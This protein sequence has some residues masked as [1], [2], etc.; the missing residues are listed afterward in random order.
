AHE[1]APAPDPKPMAPHERVRRWQ[2]RLLDLSLLNRLINFRETTR[3]LKLE[4]PDLPALENAFNQEKRFTISSKTDGDENFRKEQ[5]ERQT[6]YSNL[7]PAATQAALLDLYRTRRST[8]E[9][10]G[11]N[12]LYLALGMLHWYE[13]DVSELPRRAPILL[14]P[15][16]LTRATA[17][18][19]YRYDLLLSDEPIRPNVTLLEKLR[20]EFG[21]DDPALATLPEDDRGI[22]VA[23]VF[24]NFRTAIKGI[25]RW[26]V[27]ESAHLGLF[28]FNKFLMWR[29]LQEHLDTLKKNRLVAHL[30]Q[31][32]GNVFDPR[33][34]PAADTL[35]EDLAPGDLLCTRDAD[36]SQ[37][38]AIRA[39]SQG[40]TF[41]LEGP[42]GT[43]KSQT[44][45]NM[46]ADSI[47]RGKR[48]LFVAEKMA[49]L[50]VVRDR[51]E[52]DGLGAFCLELHSAK[53]SKKEVLAQLETA[54][55]EPPAPEP[56]DWPTLCADLAR[57][58]TL[59]NAYVRALHAHHPSGETLYQVA[60][61]LATLPTGP[62]ITPDTDSIAAV[63]AQTLAAWRAALEELH[64]AAAMLD[65]V[66]AH[67]LRG[68]A[69]SQWS[70]S[71]PDQACAA[72]DAA[73]QSLTALRASLDHFFHSF[74]AAASESLI[75]PRTL[76][77]LQSLAKLLS[78]SP[79]AHPDL[80]LGTDAPAL[81][82]SL[83]RLIELGR[84]RDARCASLLATYRPE[85]LD[86]DI[87]PH[88]DRT[89]RAAAA[90]GLFGLWPRFS[91][92]RSMR[93]YCTGDVPPIQTLHRDLES[94]LELKRE[95]AQLAANADAPRLFSAR[96]NNAHPAWDE[97]SAILAW[98]SSVAD[99]ARPL[100]EAPHGLQLLSSLLSLLHAGPAPADL[101]SA[102][103]AFLN[104]ISRWSSAQGELDALLKIT[105]P[106]PTAADPTVPWLPALARQLER[107]RGGLPDLNTW[108]TWRDARDRAHAAGLA[109]IINLYEAGTLPL[110]ELK[111]A[112]E[113]GYAAAWYNAV[114][115]AHPAIREFNARTHQGHIERF[116]SLDTQVLA[117][118]HRIVRAALAKDRP[119]ASADANP[120][121]ELGILKRELSRK[122]RHMPTRRLIASI[123]N[124]LARL[125]P[126]FL[127]SPL[128]VAQ[129]LDAR[130]PPFDLVIFDEASQI[131]VW[132]SI[133]AI[134]RGAEVIV[135]G[136][137]RQL[138][139]TSFFTIAAEDE[140]QETTESTL[141]DME[142]ILQECNASSI[143]SMWLSWHYR[144]RHES[145]IAF[146]NFHY[147]RNQLHT[148]PSPIDRS[149]QLGVTLRHI[150][151]ALYDRGNSR[152]N[153]KEAELIV[154]EI[155]DLLS[156][157]LPPGREHHDSIG[158]VTFNQTQQTLI[159][160]LLDAKRR[161]LPHLDRFFTDQ[162]P[163]P[164]FVKNLE[165]VQGDERDIIIF[166]VTYGPYEVGKPPSMHFGPLNGSGG[167]RRLNVA[168]TRARKKLRVFSSIR[169]DDIDLRRTSALGVAH[170]KTFLDYADRGP[171]AI[172]E[173]T[174]L[175]TTPTTSTSTLDAG[176]EHAVQ[177][178]LT[179]RG[180]QVD[181]HVGCAG[182]RVDLAIRDP[183]RPGRYLLGIECDGA[184]YH[185]GKTARDRDRLR[186]A[187]LRS[188]GWNITR[189]WSTDWRINPARCIE[190]LEH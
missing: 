31:G 171:R 152:T 141:D 108:C 119:D 97:L 124:L 90:S 62:A 52:K 145:L 29:D 181:A 102:A 41:V 164:V 125:K 188:L 127:M 112:F 128:S 167:E 57:E 180:W 187:V 166:S 17:T 50:G 140:E 80:I 133:G 66:A 150:P 42:P 15:V 2:S 163:E 23:R 139:P 77:S 151:G 126:C 88:L 99:A 158:V 86:A 103:A 178:A 98:S 87:L 156:Q 134:A 162:V 85:L 33:P 120:Q 26:E 160:D 104:A 183:A 155:V 6:L 168:V 137:S 19:G 144:S 56:H 190:S 83:T 60:G 179:A 12:P 129:Y 82:A 53:A 4:I 59:L 116:A 51:L 101:L 169:A 174:S 25:N 70:F 115:D 54:L 94:I 175:P 106:A 84:Q 3:T 45:A 111:P 185:S 105:L 46:I 107:W 48:V 143:P 11:A 154:E 79:S 189:V 121:S 110:A 142:S 177:H 28:S 7:P 130:L 20:V 72:L 109:P 76:D 64:R 1:P 173:A 47:G 35:D 147:Y 146:S 96:W 68:I 186:Q 157:P 61:R 117:R 37:L 122:A 138:P 8:I 71:L 95:S 75:T 14:L 21:L 22:D 118:G 123:P 9:E 172:A 176:F 27:V 58:R 44:I 91:A 148:F 5:Q 114:A 74:R 24:H 161:E 69:R 165:N 39:A 55:K 89:R 182:Y 149:D 92:R 131:P 136:D 49:A 81:R 170:F 113:R 159:E 67:D 38:A 78:S 40:H 73:A 32:P 36:S 132:D 18:S 65:P 16:E 13:S 10:T 43:G 30:L 34:L 93:P 135:V 184:S 100:L 63:S 153:R